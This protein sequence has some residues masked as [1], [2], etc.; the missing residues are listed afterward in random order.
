MNQSIQ[1]ARILGIPIVINLS[2]VITLVFVTSL[3]ALDIYPTLIPEN[4]PYRN[5][6][7]LHWVMAISSGV[8]FFVSIILHELAHSVVA[9]HQGIK[10]KNITLFIFGGVSQ[11][12]G[13]SAEQSERAIA[14]DDPGPG[15]VVKRNHYSNSRLNL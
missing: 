15:L 9:L 5:D 12:A 1:V 6:Y 10:V 3:L 8:A 7:A 4:S 13:E 14:Q 11:I 2:W